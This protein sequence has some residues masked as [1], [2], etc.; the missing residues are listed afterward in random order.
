MACTTQGVYSLPFFFHISLF[1]LSFSY[2]PPTVFGSSSQGIT[3][4]VCSLREWKREKDFVWRT[5]WAAVAAAHSC[6][7]FSSAECG[8]AFGLG[9]CSVHHFASQSRCIFYP[10]LSL[11]HLRSGTGGPYFFL[12][13]CLVCFWLVAVCL[14][15][16]K[17]REKSSNRI[18]SQYV[19]I[20]WLLLELCCSVI[21]MS[22][23]SDLLLS[24][25]KR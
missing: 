23:V 19:L 6:F 9:Y 11:G 8:F 2:S 21:R 10:I 14:P 24:F 7:F 22:F 3:Y 16:K 13:F 25:L 15:A 20:G 18:E 4:T 12:S 17:K 1:S 5:N